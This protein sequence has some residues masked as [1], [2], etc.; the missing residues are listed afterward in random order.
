MLRWTT[1]PTHHSSPLFTDAQVVD[2]DRMMC[3]DL[4]LSVVPAYSSLFTAGPCIL[5]FTI[6]QVMGR[7]LQQTF[8]EGDLE[9]PE[10][11]KGAESVPGRTI[12]LQQNKW[13]MGGERWEGNWFGQHIDLHSGLIPHSSSLHVGGEQLGR[14]RHGQ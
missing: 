5:G 4:E 3:P 12:I 10:G 2:Y 13:D 8:V 14:R 9:V 11:A 7:E 6:N 1:H